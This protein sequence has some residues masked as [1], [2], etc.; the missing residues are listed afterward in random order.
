MKLPLAF[1]ILLF[2]LYTIMGCKSKD[3][4]ET[5]RPETVLSDLPAELNLPPEFQELLIKEMLEI[6]G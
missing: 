3:T 4:A 5:A 1:I 2:T 6:H